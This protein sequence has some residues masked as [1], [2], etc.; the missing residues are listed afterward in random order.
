MTRSRVT[1]GTLCTKLVAAM[2]ASAGSPR[3]SSRQAPRETAK[4]RGQTFERGPTWREVAAAR[5][6]PV[7]PPLSFRSQRR[8][9]RPMTES[10]VMTLKEACAFVGCSKAHFCNVA[11]GKIPG[12][13]PLKR[14]RIGR[15]VLFVRDSLQEW[16]RQVEAQ[17]T[18]GK[19]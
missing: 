18:V 7:L 8:T 14:I 11:N 12:L 9:N 15:R 13:P 2:I 6:R 4:S 17:G 5:H 1:S 3:K 16:L 19:T 10:N